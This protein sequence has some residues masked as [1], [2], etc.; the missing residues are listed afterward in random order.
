MPPRPVIA[1][2]IAFIFGGARVDSELSWSMLALW[3]AV[4]A[5]LGFRLPAREAVIT[6][7]IYGS[8][9]GFASTVYGY[10]GHLLFIERIVEI[11]IGMVI[12]ALCGALV[13]LV[14]SVVSHAFLGHEKTGKWQQ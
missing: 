5:A 10:R 9:L 2:A 4:G 8:C 3:I 6:G 11:L 13:T 7:L 1:F 14:G 12:G